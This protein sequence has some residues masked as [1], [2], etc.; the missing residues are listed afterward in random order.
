MSRKNLPV[1]QHAVYG[2]GLDNEML[3]STSQGLFLQNSSN[4]LAEEMRREYDSIKEL[5]DGQ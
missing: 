4:H 1:E 3:W 5:L 2:T